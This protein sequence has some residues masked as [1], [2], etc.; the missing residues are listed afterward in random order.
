LEKDHIRKELTEK[1]MYELETESIKEALKKGWKEIPIKPRSIQGIEVAIKDLNGIII[2]D[3]VLGK[4]EVVVE[5]K[6]LILK[7]S[8]V[9]APPPP[10]SKGVK[11]FTIRSVDNVSI[12]LNSIGKPEATQRGSLFEKIRTLHI[13]AELDLEERDAEKRDA[14]VDVK[15]PL[16]AI[17]DLVDSLTRYFNRYRDNIKQCYLQVELTSEVSEET[18]VKELRKYGIRTEGGLLQRA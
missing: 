13:H 1:N 12:F 11:S 3:K 14:T 15:G 8:R 7:K 17:L 6:R 5:D 16:S 2:E 9:L 10:P 18:L 4:I